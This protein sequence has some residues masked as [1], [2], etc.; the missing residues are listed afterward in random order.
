MHFVTS[1]FIRSHVFN[2]HITSCFSCSFSSSIKQRSVIMADGGHLELSLYDPR[3]GSTQP[4]Q[5]Q[6]GY[7]VTRSEYNPAVADFL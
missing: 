4:R 3:L 1:Y 6:Y 5:R 7:F 2:Y